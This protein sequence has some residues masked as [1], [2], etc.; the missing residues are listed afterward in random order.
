VGSQDG[1]VKSVTVEMITRS[2]T[3]NA[4]LRGVTISDEHAGYVA[5]NV[6]QLF[7]ADDAYLA[8]VEMVW[9]VHHLDTRIPVDK[10]EVYASEAGARDAII[11]YWLGS[12]DVALCQGVIASLKAW[13]GQDDTVIGDH[14]ITCAI[15]Q[16]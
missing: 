9:I 5:Q 6:A 16:L 2:I 1:I 13:N 12:D 8:I 14:R 7:A 4:R 15:V 3:T 10:F 11:N